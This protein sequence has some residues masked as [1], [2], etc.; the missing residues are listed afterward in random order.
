[1]RETLFIKKNKEKWENY[2]DN[3]T[4]DPNILSDR[5]VHILDDLAYAQTFYPKGK[6][7]KY[8][9]ER[10]VTFY[11]EI[12]K[13]KKEPF[14]KLLDYWKVDMPLVIRRNH[15]YILLALVLFIV[16]VLMG[17]LSAI[18]QNDFFDTISPGYLDHT[19]ENI[20][21]GDPFGIYG[22]DGRAKSFL[23]IGL[24]NISLAFILDYI[25]GIPFGIVNTYSLLT[26]GMMVGGFHYMFYE[27]DLG[28]EFL[29]VVFIHGTFE[30]FAI[31]LGVAAGYRLF[32]SAIFIGT[33]TRLASIK[34][35]AKDGMQLMILTFIL[36]FVA[37]FLEGYITRLA[38]S[39]LAK[40]SLDDFIPI[41]VSVLLLIFFFSILIWYFGIYPI[42]VER[43]Y[44]KEF[45][46]IKEENKFGM[47]KYTITDV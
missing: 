19:R 39:S 1:M 9:N 8:L 30:L 6:T 40:N 16:F 23:E 12:Y 34:K 26:N 33:Y 14:I 5:F 31:V 27:A 46:K 41:W 20:A 11:N 7:V 18:H 43:K 3:P 15:T 10:A 13:K 17:T 29:L 47:V 42:L 24:H 38:A 37:A 4:N 2:D 36:L 21:K 25:G 22:G 44:K 45:Y 35:G 32:S 28:W